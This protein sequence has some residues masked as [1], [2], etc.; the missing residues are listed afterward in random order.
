MRGKRVLLAK[1]TARTSAKTAPIR[2]ISSRLRNHGLTGPEKRSW[3]A[4]I[5]RDTQKPSTTATN[6]IAPATFV[7]MCRILPCTFS[8]AFFICAIVASGFSTLILRGNFRACGMAIGAAIFSVRGTLQANGI[9]TGPPRPSPGM[10]PFDLHPRR[11]RQSSYA[12]SQAS[13]ST[14]LRLDIDASRNSD[15]NPPNHGAGANPLSQ[16]PE[17]GLSP[18]EM[19]QTISGYQRHARTK[20]LTRVTIL[21]QP[22]VPGTN[23]TQRHAETH[24]QPETG[25]TSQPVLQLSERPLLEREVGPGFR[26]GSGVV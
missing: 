19:G 10:R 20:P 25:E 5:D 24:D 26:H 23:S 18:T 1:Y 17:V 4:N 16:Q 8:R 15:A 9:P 13:S 22:F 3:S 21:L 11:R 12:S 6:P 14:V 7:S 2:R